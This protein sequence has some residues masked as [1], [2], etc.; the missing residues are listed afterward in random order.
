M[1]QTE[2]LVHRSHLQRLLDVG[3]RI[4]RMFHRQH[5]M[6]DEVHDRSHLGLVRLV[7]LDHV[8]ANRLESRLR[9]LDEVRRS[10]HQTSKHLV[11]CGVRLVLVRCDGI[12]PALRADRSF[13]LSVAEVHQNYLLEWGVRLLGLDQIHKA[14]GQ[15]R[16]LLVREL[17]VRQVR[18]GEQ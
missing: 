8:A 9:R 12:R 3:R 5:H 2:L 13:C 14:W 6:Q 11:R 1:Q 10:H 4:H 15:R 16:L 17:L 7:R 18:H